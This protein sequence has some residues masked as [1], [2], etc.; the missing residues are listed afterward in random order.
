VPDATI[1]FI[2]YPGEPSEIGQSIEVAAHA[3]NQ[4]SGLNALCTWRENDI[5]GRFLAHP[6]LDNIRDSKCLVADVSVLNFN[7]TYEV[8]YAIGLG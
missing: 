3:H 5:A 2:A 1:G 7:V 8:G 4:R 6:I